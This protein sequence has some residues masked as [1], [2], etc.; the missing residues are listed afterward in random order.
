MRPILY[1]AALSMLMTSCTGIVEAPDEGA[2]T[3]GVAVCSSNAYWMEK[4][5]GSEFMHPGGKCITCHLKNISAPLWKVAGT[6]YPTAHEPDECNGVSSEFMDGGMSE[7]AIV[8]TD[9]TGQTKPPIPV[10]K[11]GNFKLI[12]ILDP[13][14][15]VKVTYKGKESKMMMPATSGDCNSC[16]TQNGEQGAAGRIVLPQ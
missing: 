15:Y 2:G 10:N 9:H 14:Y 7:V 3:T 1:T 6:V 11:V 4:D 16:H 8:I 5:K 12:D 13:P